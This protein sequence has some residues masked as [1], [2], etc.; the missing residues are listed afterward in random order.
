MENE[1]EATILSIVPGNSMVV[2]LNKGTPM[3]TPK[4]HNPMGTPESGNPRMI[5]LLVHDQYLG[6]KA[7]III[8]DWDVQVLFD[9][10]RC[11]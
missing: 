3:K 6:L 8:G 10:D 5:A 11:R 9:W 7:V 1:M 2:S 4:Y